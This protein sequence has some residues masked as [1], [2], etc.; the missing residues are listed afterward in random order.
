[1]PRP[2]FPAFPMSFCITPGTKAISGPIRA[3]IYRLDIIYIFPEKRQAEPL[4]GNYLP[5]HAQLM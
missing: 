5:I 2:V 1:V 3:G 4:G